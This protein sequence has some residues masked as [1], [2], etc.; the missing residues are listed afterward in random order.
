V[1]APNKKEVLEATIRIQSQ[2][3]VEGLH[4]CVRLGLR[5]RGRANV[6]ESS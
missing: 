1:R 4:V 2:L 5:E 6:N 3:G